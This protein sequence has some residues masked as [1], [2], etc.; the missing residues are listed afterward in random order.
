MNRQNIVEYEAICPLT[1]L[2]LDS[3]VGAQHLLEQLALPLE[4]KVEIILVCRNS[5][6]PSTKTFGDELQNA[7]LHISERS[8]TTLLQAHYCY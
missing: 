7:M 1:V 8:L 2:F 3:K 6:V 5:Y 4:P